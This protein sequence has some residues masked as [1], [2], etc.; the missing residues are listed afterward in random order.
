MKKPLF[1]ALCALCSLSSACE[2]VGV[3][4]HSQGEHYKGIPFRIATPYTEVASVYAVLD[5]NTSCDPD[6]SENKGLNS[7]LTTQRKKVKPSTTVYYLDDGQSWGSA[8]GLAIKLDSNGQLTEV[9]S[10]QTKVDPTESAASVLGAVIEGAFGLKVPNTETAEET[11]A[12]AD[13]EA[14]EAKKAKRAVVPTRFYLTCMY[15][16][17]SGKATLINQAISIE[18]PKI[19]QEAASKP[20]LTKEDLEKMWKACQADA[21]LKEKEPCLSIKAT[22]GKM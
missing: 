13:A 14:T 15:E 9:T 1:Y 11:E 12:K 5:R 21:K 20:T 19:V 10:A 3:T 8:D 16:V 4:A 2:T 18:L 22:L 17:E 6:S 7:V